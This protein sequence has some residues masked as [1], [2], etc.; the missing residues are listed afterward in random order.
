MAYKHGVYG[1][2]KAFAGTMP[3][4]AIGTIPAYIGTAPIQQLNT[5]GA[6][7]FNYAQYINRPVLVS[8]LSEAQA[9]LG[10]S[11]NW[12]DFTLC[13][14]MY[15][16][17]MEGNN[18]IGPIILIN[19]TNPATLASEDTETEV[20]LTGATGSKVGYL[21]DPLAAIENIT[22]A[23]L[24]AGTDYTLAYQSD[25]TIKVTITSQSFE[26]ATATLTY[27]QI[28]VSK[29]AI[30]TAEFSAAL[31][32]LDTAENVTGSVPNVLAAPGWS[33]DPDY[34]EL[35][36][37]KAIEKI[38]QKWYITTISD[39][40]ANS[41]VN[42][43]AEAIS[44]QAE[45]GYDSM[46][47]R[48][49]WPMQ[50]TSDGKL[51]HLSTLA[52]VRTQLTDTEAN[53]IPYISPSNKSI[54]SDGS[55]LDDG[56]ELM[57]TEVDENTLNASGITTVNIVRG[58]I[59]LWGPHMSNY[60]YA[61]Q[62]NIDPDQLLDTAIRMP[63]YILNYLQRN[64]LDNV[65]N[66]IAKRDLD[67]ILSNVQ[68]W[69][70]SMVNGGQLLYGTVAFNASDNSITALASGDFAFDLQYTNTPNAKSFTFNAQ[71]TES[72]LTVLLG[73]SEEA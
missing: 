37:Q 68:Q 9:A 40:P 29:T 52:A 22:I 12:Q 33:D 4:A 44:W 14:A 2:K 58:E 20:T 25:G 66:P 23:T 54:T 59:R 73:G 61:N 50:Q 48:V 8:T 45:N 24:S 65:D 62:S 60:S 35:M 67:A 32:G 17:F 28:D 26:G 30:T 39:I 70:N 56:M 16:H 5:L 49:C 64:Y 41:T 18:P 6:S 43:G 53:G 71:Y 7:G 63:V 46:W 55:C 42:T 47:D 15:A 31:A 3:L 10:D 11:D 1:V 69:L 19:M 27:R 57:L 51:Y 36:I 34:H 38:A 72:G 13:E 21:N